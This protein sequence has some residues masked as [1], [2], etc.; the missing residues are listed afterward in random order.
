[1][2]FAGFL[3]VLLADPAL[4]RETSFAGHEL[5]FHGEPGRVLGRGYDVLKGDLQGDCVAI[6][7]R[8]DEPESHTRRFY[9][10]HHDLQFLENPG[11][12]ARAL[13]I[14]AGTSLSW[15]LGTPS[16]PMQYLE[17][18]K[19][20]RYSI[21]LLARQ[22]MITDIKRAKAPAI[23]EGFLLKLRHSKEAFRDACGDE[24]ISS[25]TYG[26]SYMGVIRFDTEDELTHQKLKSELSEKVGSFSS[27]LEMRGTLGE[28]LKN[29]NLKITTFRLGRA[30]ERATSQPTS[31]EQFLDEWV[32]FS[33]IVA[34]NPTPIRVRTQTYETIENFPTQENTVEIT[35]QEQAMSDVAHLQT[36]LLQLRNDIL[37]IRQ[38]PA[39]F[40]RVNRDSLQQAEHQILGRLD[41]VRQIARD[42]FSSF[43]Q[44]IHPTDLKIPPFD[45]PVRRLHPPTS[46]C[47]LTE[48]RV[49]G[50]IYREDR[51]PACP[52]ETWVQARQEK[53]GVELYK[54]ARSEACGVETYQEGQDPACGVELYRK[55]QDP[56]CGCAVREPMDRPCHGR[57]CR[58]L[59][60]FK[61]ESANYCSE[62]YECRKPEFGVERYK[63]CA[64]PQFGVKQ[65]KECRHPSHGVERYRTCDSSQPA[66]FRACRAEPHGIQ[67][68]NRC[69]ARWVG[70][71]DS[72]AH[73]EKCPAN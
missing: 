31:P 60:S 30:G 10:Q 62:Y 54:M 6:S 18:Q 7:A 65:Y 24:F 1:M 70:T 40:L 45:L 4:A 56:A 2:V 29:R 64:L 26:G 38:N 19:I 35:L 47:F 58:N 36:E 39:Q 66:S 67:G 57:L 33:A 21:Y 41:R 44:C 9:R 72:E 32:K 12:L 22:E 16:T 43:E 53:C 61:V 11:D 50:Y 3:L 73:L 13:L 37:F 25:M 68:V 46:D 8:S 63:T 52:V 51:S 28:I 59:F 15:G 20:N 27:S 34:E 55:R 49:C 71:P 69:L 17:S 23:K 48:H 5:G 14:N 42:C